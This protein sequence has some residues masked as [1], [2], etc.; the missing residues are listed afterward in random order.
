MLAN[1]TGLKPVVYVSDE[2]HYS[3]MRLC[4]L[5]NLDLELIKSDAMGS[6]FKGAIDDIID[7][8]IFDL[9]K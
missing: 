4:D 9:A 3:N 7:S 8:F 6:T 1:T 5:Q 2:A